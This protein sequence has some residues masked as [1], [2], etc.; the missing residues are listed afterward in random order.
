[1]EAVLQGVYYSVT[2][3]FAHTI[4]FCRLLQVGRTT[5]LSLP[6]GLAFWRVAF[7]SYGGRYKETGGRGNDELRHSKL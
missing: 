1:M 6:S 5:E 2:M 4:N 7:R 3:S